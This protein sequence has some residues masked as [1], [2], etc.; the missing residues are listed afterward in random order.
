[1]LLKVLRAMV[2]RVIEPPRKWRQELAQI[3]GRLVACYRRGRFRVVRNFLKA[4]PGH[5]TDWLVI[6]YAS[7]G[8]CR[9]AGA[10]KPAEVTQ[11]AP[12]RTAY[13]GDALRA[14]E[15][16]FSLERCHA[17]HTVMMSKLDRFSRDHYSDVEKLELGLLPREYV[18]DRLERRRKGDPWGC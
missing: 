13:L 10:G 15:S 17:H 2:K 4:T 16:L 8:D 18:L 3:D 7:P 11:V 9:A 6:A 12:L 14:A 5:K 1:M